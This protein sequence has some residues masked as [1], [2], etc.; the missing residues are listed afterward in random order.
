LINAREQTIK[1]KMVMLQ[2]IYTYTDQ[3]MKFFKPGQ[4]IEMAQT[5][6]SAFFQIKDCFFF[7]FDP[8][9]QE[10]SM[11]LQNEAAR[12]RWLDLA[13]QAWKE[14]RELY[15]N[16]KGGRSHKITQF[17][18]K[19]A[20]LIPI[21]AFG[22]TYGI[23]L[24]CN[25]P[26]TFV[27]EQEERNLL[28]Q[29]LHIASMMLENTQMVQQLQAHG[30][31]LRLLTMRI[32]D[33]SEQERK[34]ISEDI[35]DTLTQTLT[36]IH[37]RLQTCD[38]M[39]QSDAQ[40]R[41]NDFKWLNRKVQ[42]AIK[43]SRKIISVLH[44][45]VID[46]IGLLSALEN[47]FEVFSVQTGIKVINKI[48]EE[49]KIASKVSLGLYRIIQE[50]FVN[51]A[52]HS[53]ATEIEIILKPDTKKLVMSILDNGIGS[54]VRPELLVS[55][56]HGKFGLFYMQ[57]RIEGFNG[58]MQILTRLNQG[59]HIHIKIPIEENKNGPGN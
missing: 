34:K 23:V 42:E 30:E 3:I 47:Y 54:D 13:K 48:K 39:L 36:A 31:R 15:V 17:K 26:Q 40:S 33:T 52:K 9:M 10:R 6:L 8:V 28:L 38:A 21:Q 11:R 19:S 59:F 7:I 41:S 57:Q 37:F 43:Q 58:Q 53:K 18:D 22:K 49:P 4:V 46:N 20:A 35:H 1:E 16:E 2:H 27:F 45:D 12:N 25:D 51:I 55:P 14:N 32:L 56:E 24:L 44:P 29:F 5:E 50:A